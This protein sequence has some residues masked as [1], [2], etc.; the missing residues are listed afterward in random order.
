VTAM[1]GLLNALPHTPL[2]HRLNEQGRLL[3]ESTGENTDGTLNFSPLMG[4]KKL[5]AGYR[6]VLA[7]IYSP[8]YYYQRINT[9]MRNYKPNST[10]R[11]P[12]REELFAFFRST[13]H[14]GVLSR[15]RFSYWSL[16]VRTFITK[17]KAFPIAIE[18]AIAGQHF[19]RITRQLL[20]AGV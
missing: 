11:I 1:V 12:K 20:A 15:A 16:V 14:I 2:W 6:K 10:T 17:P 13:W 5:V 7:T 9:F 3:K 19:Q 4:E 18:M 8:K